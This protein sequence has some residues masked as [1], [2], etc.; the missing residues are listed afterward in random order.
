MGET[1]P[2]ILTAPASSPEAIREESWS[3]QTLYLK[4]SDHIFK[5]E[6]K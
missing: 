6:E 5:A 3:Q 1:C 4:G 2:P